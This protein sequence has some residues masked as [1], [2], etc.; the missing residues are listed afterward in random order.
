M[1]SASACSTEPEGPAEL[2][3]AKQAITALTSRCT[4]AELFAAAQRRRVL[5][6][7]VMTAAELVADEHL[8]RGATGRRWTAG[9]ARA[10]S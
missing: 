6:A 9:R 1:R 4:K 10:R 2:E 3:A 5:L 7:P 8:A